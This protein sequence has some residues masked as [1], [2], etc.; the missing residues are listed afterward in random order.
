MTLLIVWF[1]FPLV[2]A[3]LSLGCGLAV[4]RAASLELPGPLLLPMGF[5]LIS[6]LCQFAIL[7]DSTA[8]LATPAVI[9]VAI[10]GLGVSTTTRARRTCS[11]RSGSR[12]SPST[13]ATGR[14]TRS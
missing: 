11:R 6:V 8:E 10:G 1:V 9:A 2:L 5:A 13:C 7:S 3:A 12:T 14:A 4:E